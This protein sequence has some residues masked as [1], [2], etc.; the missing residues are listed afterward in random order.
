[1]NLQRIKHTMLNERL[2]AEDSLGMVMPKQS[3]LHQYAEILAENEFI[4]RLSL[5]DGK[6][7]V[8]LR[9][10]PARYYLQPRLNDGFGVAAITGRMENEYAMKMISCMQGKKSILDIGANAGFYSV[11]AGTLF[12]KAK[13]Y[14]FE[15]IPQTFR[16]L[17]ENLRLN[18]CGNVIAT[19]I[20]LTDE[21]HFEQAA[22]MYF[23]DIESGSASFRNI[24]ER[25]SAKAVPVTL[26]TLDRFCEKNSVRPDFL[27]IDVE[28]SE[29]FV[30]RAGDVVD[31]I[32]S[33][34]YEMYIIRNSD[35]VCLTAITEETEDTNFVFLPRD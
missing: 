14:A 7:T 17:E 31:Y 19:N 34:G 20:A 30:L 13:V 27:K 22:T 1:M 6:V 2:S 15:P 21:R 5:E 26:D 11:L 24:R 18:G 33:L 10:F 29:L 3:I 28:G 23:A 8:T 9:Q 16:A 25:S 12:P 4:S 35:L 32:C